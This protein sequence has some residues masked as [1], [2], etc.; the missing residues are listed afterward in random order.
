MTKSL[1]ERS[2]EYAEKTM[3][4]IPGEH[5]HCST[6][7]EMIQDSFKAGWNECHAE[8]MKTIDALGDTLNRIINELEDR[9]WV[10]NELK[11]ETELIREK[12]RI[13][14]TALKDIEFCPRS[15]SQNII[16]EMQITA[17]DAISRIREIKGGE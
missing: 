7:D 13:A 9:Q 12:L 1:D 15:I 11:K 3:E 14:F 16:I 4:Q 17:R 8:D 5:F 10:C 6:V 2:E